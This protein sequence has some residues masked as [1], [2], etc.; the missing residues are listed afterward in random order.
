MDKHKTQRNFR[1]KEVFFLD[2]NEKDLI[3][4]IKEKLE[5]LS[6]RQKVVADYILLNYTKAAFMSVSA[7]ARATKTSESTI[8][9]LAVTLG[10]PGY[11]E[12]RAAMQDL[13]KEKL[14]T[15]DRISSIPDTEG[16]ES[17]LWEVIQDD[18]DTLK[19]A[20]TEISE[21]T[22]EEVVNSILEANSIYIV[23]LR[24]SFSLA[25]FLGFY[26]S[27]FFKNIHVVGSNIESIF[28][29]MASVEEGDLV[30]AFGFP[31]YTKRTLQ[32]LDLAKQKGAKVISITDEHSPL[33][34]HSDVALIVPFT[35]ISVVDSFVVPFS[36]LNAIIATIAARKKEEIKSK[37]KELETIWKE[38]QVYWIEKELKIKEIRREQEK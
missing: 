38:N 23:G 27:W 18:L 24:S 17:I 16:S 10:Y 4:R 35:Q 2:N 11:P 29:I 25:H 7:L 21:E 22:F 30:I 34:Q 1:F 12:M 19:R 9:R 5:T 20:I 14:T 33:T 31:R 8:V 36:T 32:L 6:P 28:E 37:L 13:V 26:L 3:T 15:I